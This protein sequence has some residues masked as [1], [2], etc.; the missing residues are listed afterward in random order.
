MQT[1]ITINKNSVNIST[2][3]KAFLYYMYKLINTED[4][5]C[6]ILITLSMTF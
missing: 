6:H 5:I 2:H 4:Q 3:D 1:L